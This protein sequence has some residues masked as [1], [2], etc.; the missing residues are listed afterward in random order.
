MGLT[1][2]PRIVTDGLVF[3]LDAANKLSYAGAGNTWIDLAGSNNGTLTNG[4]TFSEEN[5]GSVAFD[6]VDDYVGTDFD[7]DFTTADFT[8][9]AWA[10]PVFDSS[11]YGRPIIT[12]NSTGGCSVYDFALE[13]G[14]SANKFKLIAQGGTGGGLSLSSTNTYDKNTWFHILTTRKQNSANDWTYIMYVNGVQD[15]TVTG[16]YN[17]GSGG[18][19]TIGK[20]LD[21]NAVAEWYGR[22]SNIKVYNRA[23]SAKEIKQNYKALKGR[24][25]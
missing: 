6:G 1:H 22:I 8:L 16:D 17:G 5:G 18:K 9:E 10:Y 19:L 15:G 24:F 11:Q 4:P 12:M 7:L 23:L 20:F 14:R 3:C 21:C 25:T 13:F 2:S